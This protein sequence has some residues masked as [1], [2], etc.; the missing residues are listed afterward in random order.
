MVLAVRTSGGKQMAQECCTL[1]SYFHYSVAL[2]FFLETK[3]AEAVQT[4]KLALRNWKAAWA[5]RL[6]GCTTRVLLCSEGGRYLWHRPPA[7]HQPAPRLQHHA[8]TI[9]V[10]QVLFGCCS[11]S[12]HLLPLP[13]SRGR[14]QDRGW[15]VPEALPLISS[16]LMVRCQER[17]HGRDTHAGDEFPQPRDRSAVTSAPGVSQTAFQHGA[18]TARGVL[19]QPVCT[20]MNVILDF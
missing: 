9:L 3:S 17:G 16:Q 20:G 8:W 5:V 14:G 1:S 15:Q 19:K 12:I 4:R 2:D 18:E 7:A 13:P 6:L 11:W 10:A